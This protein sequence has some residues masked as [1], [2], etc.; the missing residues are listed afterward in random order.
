MLDGFGSWLVHE[1]CY[2][3]KLVSHPTVNVSENRQFANAE[4]EF[5][6]RIASPIS[7]HSTAELAAEAQRLFPYVFVSF[8]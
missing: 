8:Y 7:R 5:L 1:H 6:K 4:W 2:F 3:W